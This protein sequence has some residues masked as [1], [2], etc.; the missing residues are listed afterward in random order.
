MPLV[1]SEFT[2]ANN[3]YNIYTNDNRQIDSEMCTLNNVEHLYEEPYQASRN[4][5]LETKSTRGITIQPPTN[6]SRL[7]RHNVC[8][9]LWAA[10]SKT[11]F[12]ALNIT[13][14]FACHIL[15]IINVVI[16]ILIILYM[17]G[18]WKLSDI[19]S[20]Y[21]GIRSPDM[22]A[23]PS[24]SGFLKTQQRRKDFENSFIPLNLFSNSNGTM[25][26]IIYRKILHNLENITKN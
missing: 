14:A 24:L 2:K 8:E 15:L 23:D 6:D 5:S 26:S 21:G 25:A 10:L 18:L 19:S 11:F 16:I 22:S 4:L 17:C 7:S 9:R 20:K 12:Y 1:T 3:E 13:I